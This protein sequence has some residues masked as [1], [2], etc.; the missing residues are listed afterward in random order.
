MGFRPLITYTAVRTQ[1]TIKLLSVRFNY[2]AN[3][4]TG[5]VQS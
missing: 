2:T 3:A 1:S 5:K 4:Y